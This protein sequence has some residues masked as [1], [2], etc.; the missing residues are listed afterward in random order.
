M[1]NVT[2]EL[3]QAAASN[4]AQNTTT[5]VRSMDTDPSNTCLIRYGIP[6]TNGLVYSVLSYKL[7]D[8]KARVTDGNGTLCNRDLARETCALESMQMD[9][10]QRAVCIW[11]P[12]MYPD[13]ASVPDD[14][15]VYAS[16]DCPATL[17]PEG[18]SIVFKPFCTDAADACATDLAQ[19]L[20][21]DETAM[22]YHVR[23]GKSMLFDTPRLPPSQ[24]QM[25]TYFQNPLLRA[26][27]QR[28]LRRDQ[29]PW[30][31]FT[32]LD[33]LT[34][35]FSTEPSCVVVTLTISSEQCSQSSQKDSTTS[36]DSEDPDGADDDDSPVKNAEDS[37]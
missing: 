17:L 27:I 8:K 24:K 23:L 16:G 15:T 14:S 22:K 6:V 21:L 5:H 1:Q 28:I 37:E 11:P 36:S 13:P 33:G 18:G 34:V 2:G 29:Q 30:E 19:L 32:R 35:A 7:N 9:F 4:M 31:R 26:C 12:H 10:P 20:G 25:E 3:S